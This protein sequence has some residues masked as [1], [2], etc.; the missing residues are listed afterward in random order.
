MQAGK[1]VLVEKPAA[2]TRE[3]A[4]RIDAVA[5]ETKRVVAVDYM[6]RFN[7]IIETLQGWARDGSFGVLRRV[8]VENY[9]Q[10]ESLSRDH[11][12][13]DPA[14]SG[15]ILVEHAVH[16]IDLVNGC[17]DA[18]PAFVDG[19]SIRRDDG[20][21]DRM[22]LTVVYDD[23]L[24]TQQ[25]HAF[26]RP[27]LFERTSMRFVFDLAQIEVDGWIPLSGRV[28]ALVNRNSTD[29]LKSLPGLEIDHR[30]ALADV[31]DDSRPD[32]WGGASDGKSDGE[33]YHVVYSGGEPYTVTERI[34]GVFAMPDS[35]SAAYAEALR[36]MMSDLVDA[37]RNPDH[38]LRAGILEGRRSLDIALKA[39]ERA[40]QRSRTAR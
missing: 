11:W 15:G 1:H 10:D 19:L 20:R 14:K 25:Y 28:L 2:T 8:V 7:P 16:F 12:F 5:K 39:T 29:S 31:V 38:L 9:A 27:G 3:D 35:K 17:T 40:E 37:V 30:H 34:E 33:P 23:G 4:L 21:T 22:G 36:L 24:V 26:S 32:G 18:E 13:W 6:L